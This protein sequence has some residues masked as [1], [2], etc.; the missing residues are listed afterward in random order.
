MVKL[1][2]QDLTYEFHPRTPRET[3]LLCFEKENAGGWDPDGW[4]VEE[5]KLRFPNPLPIKLNFVRFI[6]TKG[7]LEGQ[8]QF[9]SH[10]YARR[11]RKK[12]EN[13]I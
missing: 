6:P 3:F 2:R 7:T 11:A 13:K 4:S 8:R 10:L 5:Q 9:F 1:L 12:A